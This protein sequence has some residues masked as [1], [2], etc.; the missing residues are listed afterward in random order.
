MFEHPDLNHSWSLRAAAHLLPLAPQVA[1]TPDVTS[2]DIKIERPLLSFVIIVH[3]FI[4][5]LA[6]LGN[7]I[8]IYLVAV[9][10]QLRNARNAFMLNLTFSNILLVTICTPSFLVSISSR[11]WHMGTFWCK[12]LHSIQIVIVLVSAFSIA[13]IAVDRW[14]FVVY[15]RSHQLKTHHVACIVVGIWALAILLS[16]PTFIIRSTGQLYDES[17]FNIIKD[18]KSKMSG[19]MSSNPHNLL[20]H[21]N[22]NATATN[23]LGP[24][25]KE[26]SSKLNPYAIPSSGKILR[27]KNISL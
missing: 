22:V 14:I 11:G 8:I 9:N 17:L 25:P 2:G 3:L 27:M 1:Q 12:C 16:V 10:I 23:Q 19:F 15:A 24:T 21:F 26:D 7:A 6:I 4:I 5:A 18:L 20:A 13:M